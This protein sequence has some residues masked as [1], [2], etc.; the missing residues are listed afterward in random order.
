VFIGVVVG[1]SVGVAVA[2]PVGV[3]G[4]M[5]MPSNFLAAWI[6]SL[7]RVR[8]PNIVASLPKSVFAMACASRMPEASNFA[9]VTASIPSASSGKAVDGGCAPDS[10]PSE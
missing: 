8:S 6:K 10:N 3:V 2:V 7:A 5:G 1:V 4:A 9:R